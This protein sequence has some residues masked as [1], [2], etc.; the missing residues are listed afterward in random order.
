MKN[1]PALVRMYSCLGAWD[2][3]IVVDVK[4]ASEISDVVRL[5]IGATLKIP[6]L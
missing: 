3:D 6:F 2:F 4:E 1:H 5:N